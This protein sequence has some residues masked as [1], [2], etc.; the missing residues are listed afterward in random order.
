MASTAICWLRNDLR[1][2]DNDPLLTALAAHERVAVLYYFDVRQFRMLDQPAIE[3][4]GPHRLA[5]LLQS[6]TDLRASLRKIG[7]DLVVRVGSDPASAIAALV[8]ELG[9]NGIY[10]QKEIPREEIDDEVSVAAALPKDCPLHLL[11]SKT[12]Y[13]ADDLPFRPGYDSRALQVFSQAHRKNR[14]HTGGPARTLA[15]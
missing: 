10:A 13:H 11:W 9:A 12:M 2:D 3:K 15:H 6:L 7:G 14:R 1:L 5:F 8:E 4:T